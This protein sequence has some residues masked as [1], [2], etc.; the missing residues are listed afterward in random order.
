MPR[1]QELAAQRCI[2]VLQ[3]KLLQRGSTSSNVSEAVASYARMLAEQPVAVM[4]DLHKFFSADMSPLSGHGKQPRMTNGNSPC[5]QLSPSP[6]PSF[7]NGA[8]PA[9]LPMQASVG[10]YSSNKG[11]AVHNEL[12]GRNTIGIVAP[13]GLTAIPPYVPH[14]QTVASTTNSFGATDNQ[15]YATHCEMLTLLPLN[16][17]PMGTFPIEYDIYEDLYED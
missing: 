2:E 8:M 9:G 12:P 15:R 7:N 3:G 11:P 6:L 10:Q 5:E 1:A 4:E 17:N 16:N 13:M 14:A